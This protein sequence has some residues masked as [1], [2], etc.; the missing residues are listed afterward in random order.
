MQTQRRAGADWMRVG[1]AGTA[2]FLTA[3]LAAGCNS[4]GTSVP[5]GATPGATPVMGKTTRTQALITDA[6]SDQ[7]V[8]LGLTVNSVRLFDAAGKY[9]DVLTSAVTI[10]ACHLDAVS[11]PLQAA[12]NI[13]QD[14]YTSALI[15]VSS[16][17]VTYVDPATGKPVQ[18]S[19]TL[20]STTDTVTFATP[21]VV[22][23]TSAP[24][25]LDLLVGQSVAI[26]GTTAVVTPTF[27]LSQITLAA[28]PGNYRNGRLNDGFGSVVS[29][30][31]TTLT[32]LLTNGTQVSIATNASTVLSGFSTL[33]ALTSGEFVD[34][35]VAQQ[36]DGSLL[37]LRIHLEPGVAGNEVL[38]VVT[39]VTGS[40]VTSF[41]ETARQWL[42]PATP[43]TLAGTSYTV[44]VTGSTTFALSAGF[45]TLPVVGFTPAFSAAALFAGQNVA[46]QTTALSGTAATAGTVT[47]EPQTV[48]GTVAS[49]STVGG[50]T[51]YT[52]TLPSGSVLGTLTGASTVVVYTTP[53]TT[54]Y[55][56]AS[57]VAVGSTVRFHGLL[58][59]DAGALKMVAVGL[60]DGEG[61]APPQRHG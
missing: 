36:A 17:T 33:G 19:A 30:S 39:A 53:A 11:E 61:Q 51:A 54:E 5:L 58:F 43:G 6:P 37:A 15:T 48:V 59:K 4:S 16:P 29:V 55:M 21:I 3:L 44:T 32:L 50:V 25:V 38:G 9:A 31:G 18:A 28:Y 1:R 46:V 49:I 42:G 52:V 7:V 40:P 20:S 47:L 14:T 22:T 26:S 35:D 34:V 2:C 24:L 10:E 23:A 41:T 27:S 8:A 57:T 60:S 56:N 13:P 45:G 12:L